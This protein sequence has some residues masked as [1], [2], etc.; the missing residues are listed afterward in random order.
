MISEAPP[1]LSLRTLEPSLNLLVTSEDNTSWVE[2]QVNTNGGN[3]VS[4][5]NWNAWRKSRPAVDCRDQ[6]LKKLRLEPG[7]PDAE[8][9]WAS[10]MR[11]VEMGQK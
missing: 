9:A 8:R 6:I 5:D 3:R 11:V 2:A 7:S 10:V 4:N 1:T